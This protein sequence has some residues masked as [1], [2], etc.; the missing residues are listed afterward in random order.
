MLRQI[1]IASSNCSRIASIVTIRV[2]SWT[3]KI[4]SGLVKTLKKQTLMNLRNHCS[5]KIRHRLWTITAL[6]LASSSTAK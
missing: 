1:L 3:Q 4:D 6:K 5:L 2:T